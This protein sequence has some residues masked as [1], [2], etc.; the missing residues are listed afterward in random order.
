MNDFKIPYGLFR[1]KLNSGKNMHEIHF[2][3]IGSEKYSDCWMG[4][5]DKNK[6]YWYGLTPDGK[7]GYDFQFADEILNAPAFDGRSMREL[8]DRVAFDTFDALSA[9][10][11]FLY[12]CVQFY[13]CR[14]QDAYNVARL[15]CKLWQ[16]AD[17]DELKTEFEAIAGRRN[18]IVFTS[19]IDENMIAFAHC[20][21]RKEYVEGAESS[22][23]AYLE[24][25]Y[26]EEEYRKAGVASYLIGCCENWE[27]EKGCSEMASDCDIENHSSRKMHE[28]NNFKEVSKLAHYVK[29]LWMEFHLKHVRDIICPLSNMMEKAIKE[30]SIFYR[31]YSQ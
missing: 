11:W 18:E 21:I 2:E 12:E 30:E 27:K 23:V 17:Y 29:S 15:A 26:V 22:P 28:H 8:W 1:K 7:N 6:T 16:S 14:K 31:I 13:R 4:C 10:D 5:D 25:I 20:N 19:Y 9:E 24:A 3:I